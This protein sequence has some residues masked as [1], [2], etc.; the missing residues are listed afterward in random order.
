ML[1]SNQKI[2]Q[3][4]DSIIQYTRANN[5]LKSNL[6]KGLS[7]AEIEKIL[8]NFPYQIPEE[9][10]QLY[11]W[12]NGINFYCELE[13]FHY[14]TF[15]PLENAFATH[16]DWLKFN[17]EEYLIYPPELLPIFEF[18]GEY[19]AVECSLE[20][21]KRG[22]IWFIYHENLCVYNSLENM[23][24]SIL[25]CYQTNAYKIVDIAGDFETEINEEKVAQ[26]KLKYNPVRQEMCDK[27][28]NYNQYYAHP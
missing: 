17:Q 16:Q 19:Y 8:E 5:N 10:E 11:H 2:S 21:E 7:F 22:K 24:T 25:E 15:L 12:H 18:Q 27:L 4:L 20:K 6:Q 26:I 3:L 9:I 1:S 13:L 28:I 14:H 23:L